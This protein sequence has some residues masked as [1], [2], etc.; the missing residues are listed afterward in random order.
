[1]DLGA[2]GYAARCHV[3]PVWRSCAAAMAC[4]LKVRR[5]PFVAGSSRQLIAKSSAI[6][7][8]SRAST[9]HFGFLP[10]PDQVIAAFSG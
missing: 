7:P 1:M 6:L 8:A 3:S 5:G 2:L 10:R 4:L 9:N